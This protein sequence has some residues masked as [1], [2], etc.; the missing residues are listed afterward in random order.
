V[1]PRERGAL[2]TLRPSLLFLSTAS[3]CDLLLSPAAACSRHHAEE[4]RGTERPSQVK[5]SGAVVL[6]VSHMKQ[7]CNR[8]ETG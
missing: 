7:F 5:A 2:R 4:G 1:L 3:I 6:Y 8:R